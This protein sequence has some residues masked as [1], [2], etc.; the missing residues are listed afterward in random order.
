MTQRIQLG[1]ILQRDG[2]LLLVR[3]QI[4]APWELPGIPFG[5]DDDDMDA[6]MAAALYSFGITPANIEEDFFETVFLG[7]AQERLVYNLYAPVDW[8]GEPAAPAG[9]GI[10]WF[11]VDALSAIEM[12]TAIREAVLH[13]FGL[14]ERPD[15]DAQIAEALRGVTPAA[16]GTASELPPPPS[17][18]EDE[19][20]KDEPAPATPPPTAAVA[21]QRIERGR[22][23]LGTLY[24]G[25]TDA[26]NNLRK[27]APELADDILGALGDTWARPVIDRRTRSLQVVAMLAALGKTGPLRSHINGALNHGASME[28]VIET[29]RTVA[30]YAGFPAALEAWAVMEEVFAA[31]GLARP[32][33][34]P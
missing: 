20:P 32:E 30:V 8:I 7:T 5:E 34:V 23:V 19:T 4:G 16:L 26:E 17:P 33:R 13:A 25:D 29:L 31:R 22:D 24:A 27:T 12:D 14:K 1:A 21:D 6:T 15:T 3:P 11:E 18:V 9:A 2:R 28:Q 10:G